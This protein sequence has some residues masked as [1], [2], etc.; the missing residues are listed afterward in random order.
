MTYVTQETIDK[1]VADRNAYFD[2]LQEL[3]IEQD[4][5]DV[6][7]IAPEDMRVGD[8]MLYHGFVYEITEVH[9]Y[10]YERDVIPVYVAEGLYVSGDMSMY[11]YFLMEK[12]NGYARGHTSG[13]QGNARANWNRVTCKKA[14]A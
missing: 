6:E 2:G 5:F 11:K 9:V 4:K 14:A 1:T 12:Q 3:P 13:Q 8:H 10:Q 7:K